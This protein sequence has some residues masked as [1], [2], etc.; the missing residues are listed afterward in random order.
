MTPM[1]GWGVPDDRVLE[2]HD[3]RRGGP[4][5]PG[6]GGGGGGGTADKVAPLETLSYG[7]LQDIDKLFVRAKMSEAGTLSASATV[8]VAGAS[9][10]YRFKTVTK[11][12]SANVSTKLR[13][14]LAKKRLKTVKKALKKGKRLKAKVTITATDK[15][16]NKRSQKATIR[17]KR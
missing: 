17:L 10:V 16:K 4:L 8:S 15:A 9:K 7:G 2:H 12:A 6:G 3:V 14:K 1:R 13:L 5:P 11:S